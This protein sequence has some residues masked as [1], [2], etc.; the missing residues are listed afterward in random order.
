[1]TDQQT[2]GE[3]FPD[4]EYSF[5][6]TDIGDVRHVL[7]SAGN[8]ALRSVPNSV[9]SSYIHRVMTAQA[10]AITEGLHIRDLDDVPDMMG[11]IEKF[12]QFFGLEYMGKPRMLPQGL[13]DFRHKFML[14]EIIEYA[15]EQEKL[16]EAV[17]RQD[18]RDITNS[19]ELQLD[20]L[21]DE[22]YVVLGTA[23][24]QF[25]PVAFNKAWKRVHDANMKKER[26]EADGDARSKRDT[27]FDVVKPEGWVAPDH[28]DLVSDHAHKI[29]R[30]EGELNPGHADTQTTRNV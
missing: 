11:D 5:N 30:M 1:M 25:G 28:R 23:Y 9:D 19:L 15:D 22:V 2:S 10:E 4:I 3:S 29:F 26:A 7:I 27:K 8:V 17:H 16:A 24:L 20:A 13:F 12:H 21:V 14:E 18:D 6:I